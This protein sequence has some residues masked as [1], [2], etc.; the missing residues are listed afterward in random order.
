MPT[1]S[2]KQPSWKFDSESVA[3]RGEC[4]KSF[5]LGQVSLGGYSSLLEVTC[6]GLVGMLLLFLHEAY[7]DCLV[8]VVLKSLYLSNHT[9]TCF[10]NSARNV[11]SVINRCSYL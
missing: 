8:A 9:R 3:Q 11:L 2:T 10:D 5:E 1:T 7:L 4:F 6:F